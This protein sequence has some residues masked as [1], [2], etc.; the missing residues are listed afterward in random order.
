MIGDYDE[1]DKS[2]LINAR[3]DLKIL[4][5]TSFYFSQSKIQ[6]RLRWGMFMSSL[7]R[8][9]LN[10]LEKLETELKK[11]RK[12]VDSHYGQMLK[13]V[14]K[15]EKSILTPCAAHFLDQMTNDLRTLFAN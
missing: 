6:K 12:L 5:S 4:E 9:R 14:Y 13:S 3:Q 7:I 8:Q 11:T 15:S 1:D 2:E 10:E